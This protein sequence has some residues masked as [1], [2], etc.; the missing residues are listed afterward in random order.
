MNLFVFVQKIIKDFLLIFASIIIIITILRQIYYPNLAFDLKSIYIIMA[1]SFLSALLGIILYSPNDISEKKMRI[2]II[3]HF[4][5]LEILLIALASF[6]DLVNSALGGIILALQIGIIYILVRL[7]SWEN[8]KKEAE[9]INEK[10]KAFKKGI[11][12]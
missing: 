1:F 12:E 10:L 4:F 7:L 6:F 9:K 5:T 2:K 3:I 11:H 8:D